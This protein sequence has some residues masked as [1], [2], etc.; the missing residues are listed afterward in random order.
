MRLGLWLLQDSLEHWKK[1][2]AGLYYVRNCLEAL[3]T[4]PPEKRPEVSIFLPASINEP[5]LESLLQ[6]C[7]E[8]VNE[9]R[10]PPAVVASRTE[11]QELANAHPCEVYFPLLNHPPVSLPG[12]WI[13]WITDLQHCHYPQFFSAEELEHRDGLFRFLVATCSRIICSSQ[14]VEADLQ[15]AYR[16]RSGQTAVVRFSSQI[17]REVSSEQ[18]TRTLEQLRIDRP[19]V[20]LPNQFWLHKNH[21]T[22]FAAWRLLTERNPQ[23]PLLVC[24]G[25]LEEPRDNYHV[26]LLLDYLETHQLQDSVRILGLVERQQQTVLYH[27]AAA[28][29]Q[30]SL[31]EGWSTTVEEAKSLGRP[32]IL[33][34]IPVHREQAEGLASFFPALSPEALADCVERVT[35]EQKAR[36][37]STPATTAD[38]LQAFGERLLTVFEEVAREP[39]PAVAQ[40]ALQL[41]LRYEDIARERLE[42]IHRLSGE[43]QQR[44]AEAAVLA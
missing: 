6:S 22:A 4:L 43:L 25:A 12:H 23:A 39:V 1:W 20:Y 27:A 42:L 41:L 38:C 26:P 18:I 14:T 30:P 29:L 17:S 32:L 40:G 28:F 19:F 9:I 16:V 24:T 5:T 10:I 11:L 21:S 44:D 2:I 37:E 15:R 33:S 34:D 8:W 3:A 7:R 31:F 36:P 35:A 13:G